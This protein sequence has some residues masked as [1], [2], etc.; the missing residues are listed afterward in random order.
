MQTAPT[1]EEAAAFGHYFEVCEKVISLGIE[2]ALN[3]GP[4]LADAMA[5]AAAAGLHLRL[6]FERR[7]HLSALLEMAGKDA[8]GREV[9][10]PI[11]H[12]LQPPQDVPASE[13]TH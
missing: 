10:M 12:Y 5:E 7:P 13:S 4:G 3:S 8:D 11:F 6:V 2:H 1:P 9:T